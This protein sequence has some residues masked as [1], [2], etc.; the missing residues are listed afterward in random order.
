MTE[1]EI[2]RRDVGRMLL[3]LIWLL[4]PINT[5][6]AFYMDAPWLIIGAAAV[7]IAVAASG[8]AGLGA[9][10]ILTRATLAVALVGSISLLLGASSGG[11]WQVDIHMV[12]FAAVALIAVL[13]DPIA[14]AAATAAV[15]IHH[16]ALNYLLPAAVYPG[17]GDLGRVVFHAVVLL[18]EAGGLIWMMPLIHRAF[19]NFAIESERAAAA[20]KAAEDASRQVASGKEAELRAAEERQ[21][22]QAA[23]A[24]QQSA[25]AAILGDRLARV[26]HGDLTARVTES[27]EGQYAEMKADFNSAIERLQGAL[28]Q[29]S[30]RT[31]GVH[32]GAAHI[33]KAAE[34]LSARSERQA[35]SLAQTVAALE[36]IGGN[37][38]RSTDGAYLAREVVSG[39]DADA[40]ES[41]AIVS[42]AVEAMAAITDSSSRIGQIVGLIDE[43]A[44]QTNLLALN[45]GVE[46]A[47]A[48]E[49]GRGFA[50]VASEVRALAQRSAQAAKEIKA[51]ISTSIAQVE[52]GAML[53]AGAG[54]ALD[55]IAK[56]VSEINGVVSTIADGAKD[57]L[58]GISE[59]NDAVGQMDRITQENASMAEEA[60]AASRELAVES[61]QLG[62][63]MR[64]FQVGESRAIVEAAPKAPA[65]AAK[66]AASK[67]NV[68]RLPPPA[69]RRKAANDDWNEF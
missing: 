2:H 67:P 22:L 3:A 7:A 15:A 50:V 58:S 57:Q 28:R 53:V 11:A 33:A 62:E 8:V 63:L 60:T 52:N 25:M 4:A 49:T 51:L 47:R 56:K 43:I 66:S 55:R 20:G 16:L 34:D 31:R 36:R 39:A 23:V 29:V 38:K 19:V 59:I 45:A 46:A 17:G 9:P 41:G 13:C 40:K 14:I 48:G 44:F 1:L 21:A 10:P 24:E 68:S 18:I 61:E 64:Q 30:E 27:L 37:I 69:Q 42:K 26:A 6:V 12:Y 54:E 5:G 65:R 32:S 35:E